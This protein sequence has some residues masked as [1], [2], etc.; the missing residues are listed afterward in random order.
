[1]ASQH[2]REWAVAGLLAGVSGTGWV[3]LRRRRD[4]QCRG[5]EHARGDRDG[6]PAAA[7]FPDEMRGE[8]KRVMKTKDWGT[9]GYPLGAWR[10]KADENGGVSVYIRA[11]GRRRLH[12]GV[13]G[14]WR[15][16]GDRQHPGLPRPDGSLCVAGLRRASRRSPWSTTV[17]ASRVPRCSAARGPGASS[18]APLWTAVMAAL[19]DR[20]VPRDDRLGRGRWRMRQSGEKLRRRSDQHR[21]VP[22][23]GDCGDGRGCGNG[24]DDAGR[25]AR[26]ARGDKRRH[27]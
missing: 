18:A 20:A 17:A 5:E 22:D 13:Q 4:D 25:A 19:G 15:E 10:F 21:E 1:M 8:W 24:R 27:R 12:D 7:A 2:M 16:P 11:E 9:D 14:R 26:P 23:E 6:E 3:R